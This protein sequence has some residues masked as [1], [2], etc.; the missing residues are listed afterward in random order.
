MSLE[1]NIILLSS[2]SLCS[3]S[4]FSCLI[5]GTLIF[6]I[7]SIILVLNNNIVPITIKVITTILVPS[8]NKL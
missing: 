6:L 8:L 5:L 1:D 2:S 7:K 3:F 4:F